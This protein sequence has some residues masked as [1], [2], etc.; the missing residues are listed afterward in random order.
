MQYDSTDSAA[1]TVRSENE[2]SSNN[3]DSLPSLETHFEVK[4][5]DGRLSQFDAQKIVTGLE[6]SMRLSGRKLDHNGE[7]LINTLCSKITDTLLQNVPATRVMDIDD[8]HVQV[9]MSLILNQQNDLAE[10]YL[11]SYANPL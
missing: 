10:A 8:I 5:K 6:Q 11:K 1:P 7:R 3:D 9:E 2:L 4:A